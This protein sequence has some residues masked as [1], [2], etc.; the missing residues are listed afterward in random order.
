[1]GKTIPVYNGKTN[2]KIAISDKVRLW[3]VE[4]YTLDW[5]NF[6][7]SFT[8]ILSSLYYIQCSFLT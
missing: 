6:C 2:L 5:K 7:E 1:M 3:N 8:N 4:F